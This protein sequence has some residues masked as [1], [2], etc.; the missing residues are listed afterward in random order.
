MRAVGLLGLLIG[1]LFA[2]TAGCA[3]ILGIEELAPG[4]VVDGGADAAVADAPVPD[5]APPLD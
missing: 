4:D 2:L 1:A 3:S 5:A